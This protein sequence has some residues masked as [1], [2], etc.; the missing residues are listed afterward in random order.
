M[1]IVAY[2]LY[3]IPYSCILLYRVVRPMPSSSAAKERLPFVCSKARIICFFSISSF[4]KDNDTSPGRGL[5]SN[6]NLSA[7]TQSPLVN[8]TAERIVPFSSLT[9]P[10]HV[11]TNIRFLASESKPFTCVLNS[12]LASSRK[13]PQATGCPHGTH[14]AEVCSACIP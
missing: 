7:V 14:A 1:V 5:S 9:L 6:S 8:S 3:L 12:L 10:T 13:T 4:F 2:S 11:W